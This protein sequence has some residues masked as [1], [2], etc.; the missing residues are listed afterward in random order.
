MIRTIGKAIKKIA[1]GEADVPQQCTIGMPDPQQEIGIWLEGFGD[2][3][4][5]TNNHVVACASPL[6]VG[7]GVNRARYEPDQ[8]TRL[9]LKFRERNREQRV[10]ARLRLEA[11][12]TVSATGQDLSLFNIR[13]C[14]NY[15]L[16]RHRIWAHDLHQF[17]I[18]RRDRNPDIPMSIRGARSM[19]VFFICPRP[20][21]L[22]SAMYGESGN[23]FPMNLFGGIGEGYFA[24]ALNS[25]RKAAPLVERAGRV[26]LSSIPFEQAGLARQLGKNHRLERA[27]WDELPF[28]TV[29][30]SALGVPVPQFA[31]RVREMEIETVRKLGSHTLFLARM[32]RDERLADGLQF[33]MV[34]GIYQAWRLKTFREQS[35][36][37]LETK[38]RV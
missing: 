30:S 19:N 25:L 20:V 28:R 4:D 23:I 10:L 9:S 11:S 13:S 1:L 38:P 33:C 37:A 16:G 17:F 21:V 32:I 14:S 27:N 34:H 2:P 15:C 36:I 12:G 7:I 8:G 18:R 29:S 3:L 24:F 35:Q 31:V 26:A 6:T 5:V 22:V